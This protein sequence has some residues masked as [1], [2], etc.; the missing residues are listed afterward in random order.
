M[1]NTRMPR[2]AIPTPRQKLAAAIPYTI[3][4]T[5]PRNDGLNSGQAKAEVHSGAKAKKS[6]PR[7]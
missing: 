4:G 5:I 3:K 7:G 6:A 1:A 2:G